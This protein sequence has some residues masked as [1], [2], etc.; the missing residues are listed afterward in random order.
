V[1][2]SMEDGVDIIDLS[3]ACR[4]SPLAVGPQFVVVDQILASYLILHRSVTP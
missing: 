3:P 2:K 1:Q 4:R